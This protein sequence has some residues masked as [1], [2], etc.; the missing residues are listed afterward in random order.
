MGLGQRYQGENEMFEIP[1]K[2]ID[3]AR[4]RQVQS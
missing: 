3:G 2:T 1:G 4:R